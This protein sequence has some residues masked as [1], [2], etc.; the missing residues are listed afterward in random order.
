[1]NKD[2]L[3]N[4]KVKLI[5]RDISWLSFN[6]RVLQ[7][8]ADKTLPLNERLKFLGIFSNNL[9]EFFRVRIGSYKR[10]MKLKKN[11]KYYLNETPEKLLS[12][13]QE[14]VVKQQKDF[15]RVYAEILKALNKE[16]TFIVDE[17]ALDK[18]QGD[19]VKEYFKELV[20]PRLVPIMIQHTRKI[21]YL[22]D[23]SIYLAVKL[24]HRQHNKEVIYALI[25]VPDDI[26][27]FLQIPATQNRKGMY[28]IM[29]D[30]VIRYCLEDIFFIFKYDFAEAHALKL[31]RDAELD[32]DSDLSKSISEKI[33]KSLKL[34]NKGDLVR[35]IYDRNMPQDLLHFLI[36]SIKIDKEQA[37]QAGGRYHNFKD[38]MNFPQ[39]NP[40]K[41]HPSVV[42][43]IEHPSFKGNVSI[44]EVLKKEDVLLSFPY[45]TFDHI[46]DFLREAAIDPHVST[47]KITLYRTAKS[48]KIT[49]A[50]IN[51]LRNGKNVTVI[52]ELQARFDEESNLLSANKLQEE[53]AQIIY[54]VPGLKVHSKLIYITRKENNKTS[55]YAHI[56]TG[57]FNETTA[58]LYCDFSLLT[59]DNKIVSEVEKVFNFFKNNY[60]TGQYKHML[61]A[62]FFM[63]NKL[64][65][66]IQTEIKNAQSGKPAQIQLKL[67][68][69]TDEELIKKLYIASCSGVKIQIIV[70]GI[71]ALV[72][73]IK[74]MSENIEAISLVD[75]YLEHARC[76][77]FHNN[78]DEVIYI[79]S[80]DWMI[81]NLDHR[82]EVACPIYQRNIKEDIKKIFE[83]QWNGSTK[84][85]II[86]EKQD[87]PYRKPLNGSPVTRAQHEVYKYLAA[88][89]Q[90]GNDA[91]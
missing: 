3:Q 53:G 1:M 35:L 13:I 26:P 8:A 33:A 19:F 34:R 4:M 69:L 9:D 60:K 70:R 72:P 38:F 44:F 37:L 39:I 25:Q 36:K 77:I 41:Q 11:A 30:D 31:T 67:N 55:S 65:K 5:N 78:G 2:V 83:I 16:N 27:R 12:K 71:C 57:N 29:L 82:A 23:K 74:N 22:R 28:I 52:I 79:S 61:V 80:A 43:T 7:E 15:D 56:G 21:P 89:Y 42:K 40:K 75:Q 66:H 24:Y 20:R 51:A 48:S 73:G 59:A 47:I 10:M 81:R 84:V 85:R 45:H 87:N 49:N 6:A 76:V 88:K 91:L 54:G 50:L 86:N 63:R 32:I 17:K 62:P 58:K 90:I 68:S 64:V 46:I 18:K 14:I